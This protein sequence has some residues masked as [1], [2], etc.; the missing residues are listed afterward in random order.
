MKLIAGGRWPLAAAL[1]FLAYT[2]L[3]VWNNY[4]AQ[5]EL[6]KSAI[7]RV[8]L[9]TEKRAAAI[10]YFFSERRKDVRNLAASRAVATFFTNQALK[11]SMEYG[12]RANLLAIREHFDYVRDEN[13]FGG[14]ATYRRLALFGADGEM[15]VDT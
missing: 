2:G 13:T 11:M 10:T 8:K 7:A 15:L 3:L 12:L 6:R 14:H 5:V 4:A 1:L 9:D